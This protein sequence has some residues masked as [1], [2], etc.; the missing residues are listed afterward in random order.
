MAVT[1]QTLLIPMHVGAELRITNAGEVVIDNPETERIADATLSYSFDA[2]TGVH[3]L[4][5]LE[6]LADHAHLKE[7]Q[8]DD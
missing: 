7:H 4:R 5:L 3:I 1:N 6:P 2:K 8:P